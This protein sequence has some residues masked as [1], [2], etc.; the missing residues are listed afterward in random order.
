MAGTVRA[1]QGFCDI[2]NHYVINS[3]LLAA[4]V[5]RLWLQVHLVKEDKLFSSWCG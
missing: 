4:I 3:A 1:L 2:D 5:L